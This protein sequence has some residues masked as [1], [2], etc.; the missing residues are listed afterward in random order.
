MTISDAPIKDTIFVCM[1]AFNELPENMIDTINSAYGMAANP[2][3]I[4]FGVHNQNSEFFRLPVDN[5]RVKVVNSE[6]TQP[7]GMELSRAIAATLRGN[8]EYFLQIDAHI[9]F[10]KD[11]DTILLKYMKK[12]KKTYE[13]PVISQIGFPWSRVN[14][15]ILGYPE[16]GIPVDEVNNTRYSESHP[17]NGMRGLSETESKD[18]FPAFAMRKI[19]E[20]AY[21]DDEYLYYENHINH[22]GF[23]FAPMSYIVDVPHDHQIKYLG[24]EHLNSMRSWTRGYRFFSIAHPLHWH[25]NK[26][27]SDLHPQDRH[28]FNRNSS[29]QNEKLDFSDVESHNHQARDYFP[30]MHRYIYGKE[31]GVHGAPDEKSWKEWAT[32]IGI[33]DHLENYTGYINENF[34]P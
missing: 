23:L 33:I 27:A 12:L 16:D 34:I 1:A 31:F 25:Y 6:C 18:G 7:I 5:R 19:K 32:H 9:L 14:G 11:W 21:K 10:Q 4:Y 29:T 28:Y 22:A 15:E 8:Q 3:N 13:L 2:E 17:W 26:G 24:D 30:T 20:P